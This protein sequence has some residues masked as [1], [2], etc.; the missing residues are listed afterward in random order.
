MNG[1]TGS[2]FNFVS[3]SWLSFFGGRGASR[4]AGNGFSRK[5]IIAAG[6][7]R[8]RFN[9]HDDEEYMVVAN[10]VAPQLSKKSIRKAEGVHGVNIRMRDCITDQSK[11]LS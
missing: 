8:S 11:M 9:T 1:F 10:S 5:Y 6:S 3:F 4:L 7:N 2:G